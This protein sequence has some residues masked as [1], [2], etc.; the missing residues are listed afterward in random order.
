M[1]QKSSTY[2]ERPYGLKIAKNGIPHGYTSYVQKLNPSRS[3][4]VVRLSND[5]L[6]RSG[7]LIS[8][9]RGNLHVNEP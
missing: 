2:N 1:W 8:K 3:M 4:K 5:A 6:A 9:G 7:L